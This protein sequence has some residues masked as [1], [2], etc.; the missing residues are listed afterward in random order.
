MLW[1]KVAG[2]GMVKLLMG[3]AASRRRFRSSIRARGYA[4]SQSGPTAERASRLLV[5][6]VHQF[7]ARPALELARRVVAAHRVDVA[8]PRLAQEARIDRQ[9][10]LRSRL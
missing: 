4:P 1:S 7:E 9:V 2:I 8:L 3:A 5:A 6:R 10:P